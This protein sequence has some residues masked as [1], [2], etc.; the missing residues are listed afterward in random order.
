MMT[1][2][3]AIT[4][5]QKSNNPIFIKLD[6]NNKFIDKVS[7]REV[8]KYDPSNENL[9][10]I[11]KPDTNTEIRIEHGNI[12]YKYGEAMSFNID[13]KNYIIDDGYRDILI[14]CGYII[15]NA[16]SSN[17]IEVRNGLMNEIYETIQ[18]NIKETGIISMEGNDNHSSIVFDTTDYTFSVYFNTISGI[19][20]KNEKRRNNNLSIYP[21]DKTVDKYSS[22]YISI[23][24][25]KKEQG[26]DISGSKKYILADGFVTKLIKLLG[27]NYSFKSLSIKK[28]VYNWE[29]I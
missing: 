24:A 19:V 17:G 25:Q 16:P 21:Y 5:Q 20:N 29:G 13:E 7:G 28:R 12:Q 6:S 4:Q 8:K 9:V 1:A 10:F 23:F 3:V 26:D 14:K 22:A 2:M 18:S 27:N 11:Y 15:K